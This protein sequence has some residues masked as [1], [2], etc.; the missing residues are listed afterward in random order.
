MACGAA[1]MACGSARPPADTCQPQRSDQPMVM[2][3]VMGGT[4]S[5][6]CVRALQ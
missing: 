3:M 6:S 5:L 1:V 4:S 2:A